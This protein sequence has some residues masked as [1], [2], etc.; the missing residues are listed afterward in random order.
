MSF[1]Y[2][3]LVTATA[4]ILSSPLIDGNVWLFALQ[5]PRQTQ[6][7]VQPQTQPTLVETQKT[8]S[9]SQKNLNANLSK[10]I[11][12]LAKEIRQLNAQQ[13][14]ILDLIF[15]KIEQ[16]RI[17][18][19]SDKFASIDAQLRLLDAKERQLDFRLKNIDKELLFRNFLNR[20]D[21][22]KAIKDEIE[23]EREQIKIERNRL[24]VDKQR[25]R[26]DIN[27][28]NIQLDIIRTRLLTGLSGQV[29]GKE[30]LN[31]L[32]DQEQTIPMQTDPALR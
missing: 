14:Q 11:R 31:Y 9:Q 16:E 4:L 12:T 30:L 7:Q 6:P 29:N 20:S 19:L 1:K 32:E 17:D 21:A 25:L 10:E 5:Q 2:K 8:D 13:R 15:L 22:E 18:K 26:E 28:G 3:L 23:N 27:A 24:E